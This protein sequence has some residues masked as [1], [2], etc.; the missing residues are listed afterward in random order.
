[1]PEHMCLL[2]GL[3][4][5]QGKY[6]LNTRYSCASFRGIRNVAGLPDHLVRLEEEHRG[7][8]E[9]QFLRSLEIDDE[10]ELHDMLDG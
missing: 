9:A 1:M 8:R 7:E 5:S 2:P 4:Q 6:K 3:R 10:M